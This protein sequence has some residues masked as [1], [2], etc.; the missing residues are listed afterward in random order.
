MAKF[1]RFILNSDYTAI[2]EKADFSVT[3]NVPQQT[4]AGAG[5]SK[6]N[7][8]DITVPSGV[9]IENINIYWSFSGDTVPA[10]YLTYRDMTAYGWDQVAIFITLYKVND[11]TY[12]LAHFVQNNS[13]Q[14]ITNGPYTITAKAHLFISSL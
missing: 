12:R 11:T 4:V 2:K 5:G 14:S 10:P 9:Y 8:V 7:Y 3:L 6:L 13:P 1:S